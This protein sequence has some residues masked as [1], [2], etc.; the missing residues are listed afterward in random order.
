MTHWTKYL[1]E[2]GQL[3]KQGEKQIS[4]LEKINAYLAEIKL[5]NAEYNANEK[6]INEVALENWTEAEILA[7]KEFS[8][9][10]NN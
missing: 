1:P 5:I 3:V 2:V 8:K 9:K 10:Q 4:L 6:H 7:A